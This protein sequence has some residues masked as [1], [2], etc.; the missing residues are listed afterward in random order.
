MASILKSLDKF[1]E[2][3][4]AR[5]CCDFLNW[6]A[7][8][9]PKNVF[10][11]VIKWAILGPFSFIMK[12]NFENHMHY[13]HFY[14]ASQTGKN[15]LA[16][17]VLYIWNL[18]FD[19]SERSTHNLGFG[20]IN[21]EARLGYAVSKTTYPVTVHEVGSLGDPNYSH[22]KEAMKKTRNPNMQEVNLSQKTLM[23]KY[24]PYLQCS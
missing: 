24:R 20:R 6:L 10:A 16:D 18:V 8:Q 11:T 15:T 3:E 9:Y 22:I 12:V 14:D 21:T 4:A 23:K 5:Q 19:E 17:I 13:L 1:P 2:V 7:I